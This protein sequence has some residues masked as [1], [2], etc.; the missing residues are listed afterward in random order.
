MIGIIN[1]LPSRAFFINIGAVAAAAVM[2][3]LIMIEYKLTLR[4]LTAFAVSATAILT[5]GTGGQIARKLTYGG[6][7]DP[8]QFFGRFF[9]YEGTHYIGVVLWIMLLTPILWRL[10]MR[11]DKGMFARGGIF[12]HMGIMS[13]YAVIQG[14]FGRMGCLSAGCCHGKSYYGAFAV[15]CAHLDYPVMPAVQTELVLLAMT[16]ALVIYAYI[17]KRN[18]APVLCIGYGISVFVAEFMYERIGTVA[19]FGLTLIQLLALALIATGVVYV[20]KY[21]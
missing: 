6:W 14:F 8:A 5:S 13:V 18:T 10:I 16:T 20:E 3:T 7:L 19:I 12:R 9:E 11:R 17:R 1:M 2:I 15:P 21:K 4:A